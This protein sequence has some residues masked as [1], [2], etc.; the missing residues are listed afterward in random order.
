M[1]KNVQINCT[2]FY[3]SRSNTGD[4]INEVQNKKNKD[5]KFLDVCKLSLPG[6]IVG[7]LS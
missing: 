5:C 7:K 3:L 2:H 1:Y 4:I 6:M